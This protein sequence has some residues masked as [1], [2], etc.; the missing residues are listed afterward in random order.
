MALQMCTPARAE[1]RQLGI[2]IP[3][4][5]YAD[6]SGQMSLDAFLALPQEALKTASLIPSFGYSKNFLAAHVTPGGLFFRRAALAAAWPTVYRSFN[7][8]LS[9]LRQR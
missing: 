3:V 6:A 5:W 7:R 1:V 8:L 4:D 2:D 9:P